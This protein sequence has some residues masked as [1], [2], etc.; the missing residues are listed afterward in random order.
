MKTSSNNQNDTAEDSLG[1]PHEDIWS[2]YAK[3]SSKI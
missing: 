3:F 1:K 2:N